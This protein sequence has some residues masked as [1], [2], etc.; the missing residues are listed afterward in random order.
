MA[1][2]SPD[3][4]L[5]P[6]TKTSLLESKL[7]T[8]LVQYPTKIIVLVK[9]FYKQS[10]TQQKHDEEDDEIIKDNDTSISPSSA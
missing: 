5:H 8:T 1:P 2:K 4:R 7:N 10:G 9:L 6:R 3:A